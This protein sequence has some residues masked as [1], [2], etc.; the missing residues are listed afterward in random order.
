MGQVKADPMDDDPIERR[1]RQRDAARRG[2]LWIGI[3][4]LGGLLMLGFAF[5][6]GRASRAEPRY[7]FENHRG[8]STDDLDHITDSLKKK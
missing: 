7:Q 6:I 2:N 5:A 1:R 8:T 4:V 3:A